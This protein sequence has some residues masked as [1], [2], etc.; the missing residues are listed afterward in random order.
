MPACRST[1]RLAV[2]FLILA[3]VA[4]SADTASAQT[5][6]APGM[7]GMSMGTMNGVTMGA[8]GDDFEAAM[9]K[10]MAQMDQGM[11]APM[12]GDPDRDFAR[13]MIPHHQGAIDMAETELRFGKDKRLRRLA[14]DIIAAQRKEIAV[15]RAELAKLDAAAK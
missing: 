14:R 7:G 1:D 4:A 9:Q 3:A 10:A 8:A 15:M 6:P 12:T 13:M 2:V 11:K 5:A